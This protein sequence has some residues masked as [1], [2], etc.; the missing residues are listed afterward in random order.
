MAV[1]ST[2][3]FSCGFDP[4][5]SGSGTPCNYTISTLPGGQYQKENGISAS[6]PKVSCPVTWT[7]RPSCLPGGCRLRVQ[8]PRSQSCF[9]AFAG[10]ARPRPLPAKVVVR[11]PFGHFAFRESLRSDLKV[12]G[13]MCDA[14][15]RQ[16][17]VLERSIPLAPANEDSQRWG[18]ISG[19]RVLKV[20]DGLGSLQSVPHSLQQSGIEVR[21]F[22]G[23]TAQIA[24][25]GRDREF[26]RRSI[27]T[28]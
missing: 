14:V 21:D 8:R 20:S 9:S 19:S 5:R 6:I 15:R 3:V 11:L 10:A 2:L 16:P 23:R 24:A 27:G 18:P 12:W 7:L 26:H 25:N 28:R 22:I 4:Q 17:Q 13:A 1:W